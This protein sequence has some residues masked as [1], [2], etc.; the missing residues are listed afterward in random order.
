LEAL[1]Q[2]LL[3][4]FFRSIFDDYGVVPFTDFAAFLGLPLPHIR[5][6]DAGSEMNFTKS[7]CKKHIG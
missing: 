7:S 4:I 6:D 3:I 2:R 5:G 1:L